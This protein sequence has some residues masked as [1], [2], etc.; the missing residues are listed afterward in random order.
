MKTIKQIADQLGVTK[1][2]VKY[3][4]RKLPEEHVKKQEGITY[5]TDAGV[6]IIKRLMR[7]KSSG[8][9][10]VQSSDDA[11]MTTIITALTQQLAEKDKQLAEKDKQITQL[12]AALESGLATAQALHA[13]TLQQQIAPP[14]NI[15]ASAD[16][17]Q[18]GG[19]LSKLFKR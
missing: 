1:D 5:I 8:G 11:I 3:Q 13:G 19:F 9:N 6:A 2:K 12:T 4:V 15:E 10:S 18:P 16:Q 17:Q 7:G 14:I